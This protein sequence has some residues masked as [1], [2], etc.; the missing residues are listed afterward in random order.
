VSAGRLAGRVAVITGAGSGL[1]AATARR[2]VSEGARVIV[3]EIQD[4]R[5]RALVDELGP[6]S[7]FIATDVTDEASVA[8]AVDLAVA[9]FGRRDVMSTTLASSV[10]SVRSPRSI[11]TSSTSLWPSTCAVSPPGSN[12]PR[13]SW[14]HRAPA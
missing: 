12:T 14:N 6:S 10:P 5:G 13:A 1:G 11:S 8:A 7:R 3:A 9:T 2:F 4:Q